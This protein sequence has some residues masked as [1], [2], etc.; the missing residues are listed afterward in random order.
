[1]VQAGAWTISSKSEAKVRAKTTVKVQDLLS[2]GDAPVVS[3]VY[4]QSDY[5]IEQFGLEFNF[6]ESMDTVMTAISQTEMTTSPNPFKDKTTIT[7]DLEHDDQVALIVYDL[8]GRVEIR[9]VM[10]FEQ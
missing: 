6:S 8:N 9:E 3:E 4:K 10:V 1:M 5:G 7:F 2:L